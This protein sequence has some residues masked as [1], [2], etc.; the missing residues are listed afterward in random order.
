MSD[1]KLQDSSGE[2]TDH[3][4]LEL[5]LA[6]RVSSAMRHAISLPIHHLVAHLN[7]Y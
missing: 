5:N 4:G 7:K 1:K 2:R 3:F 6:H